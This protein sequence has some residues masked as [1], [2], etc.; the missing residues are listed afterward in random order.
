MRAVEAIVF[1]LQIVCHQADDM[2]ELLA[3]S[4]LLKQLHLR[5]IAFGNCTKASLASSAYQIVHM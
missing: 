4:I 5:M 1:S 3:S 2:D